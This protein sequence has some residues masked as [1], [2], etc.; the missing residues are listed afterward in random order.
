MIN[1]ENDFYFLHQFACNYFH[2]FNHGFFSFNWKKSPR[3]IL[4]FFS[5]ILF[6]FIFFH[7]SQFRVDA[8]FLFHLKFIW[9]LLLIFFGFAQINVWVCMIDWMQT[10]DETREKIL[11]KWVNLNETEEKENARKTQHFADK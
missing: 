8:K 10:N 9:I 3:T 1:R 7:L 4:I 11:L 2:F 6:A 5:V